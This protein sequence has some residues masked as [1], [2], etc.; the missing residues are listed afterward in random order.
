MFLSCRAARIDRFPSSSADASH[1]WKILLSPGAGP[2]RENLSH[3]QDRFFN[4]L[5]GNHLPALH[6]NLFKVRQTDIGP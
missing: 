6:K 1:L 2:A 3:A 5:R 4:L